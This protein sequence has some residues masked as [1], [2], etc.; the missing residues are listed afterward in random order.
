MAYRATTQF[1]LTANRLAELAV[2]P[3]LVGVPLEL[4]RH[5]VP[6]LQLPVELVHISM[7]FLCFRGLQDRHPNSQV[8]EIWS[9]KVYDYL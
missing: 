8:T 7:E 6:V 1:Q 3:E 5:L 4:L 9:L 2:K